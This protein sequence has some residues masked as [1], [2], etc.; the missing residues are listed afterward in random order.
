MPGDFDLNI[1]EV[2]QSAVAETLQQIAIEAAALVREYT[3][4]TRRQTLRAVRSFVRGNSVHCGL[5][6]GRK[7]P[8]SRDT[9]THRHFKEVWTEDVRPRLKQRFP[10]LLDDNLQH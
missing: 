5:Y 9:L 10:E 6:F 4:P 2:L 8:K 7:F 1:E 3:W